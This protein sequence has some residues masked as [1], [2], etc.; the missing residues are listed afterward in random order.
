MLF[1]AI[2]VLITGQIS[3]KD[4]LKSINLDVMIFCSA[5]LL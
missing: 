5:C 1:G 2:A 3:P 4:A